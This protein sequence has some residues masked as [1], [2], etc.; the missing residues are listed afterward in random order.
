M[1]ELQKKIAIDLFCHPTVVVPAAFGVSLLMLSAILGSGAAGWGFAFLLLG[2][3]LFFTNL[4]F[5]LGN[6]SRNALKTIQERAKALRNADLDKLSKLLFKTKGTEDQDILRNIRVLYDG[7]KADLENGTLNA[8]IPSEMLQLIDD[9]FETCVTKLKATYSLYVSAQRTTGDL[10][11]KL[12]SQRKST[13]EEIE[14]SLEKLSDTIHEVRLLG[15]KAEKAE[16]QGLR[17]RLQNQ[18]VVAKATEEALA[19]LATPSDLQ[20]F[21]EYE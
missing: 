15:L 9:I 13:M 3:G 12:M 10:H 1:K 14:L 5:N 6:I 8:H 4:I 7:F 21:S 2:V 20:R 18:L 17:N 19:S 11:E 16:L